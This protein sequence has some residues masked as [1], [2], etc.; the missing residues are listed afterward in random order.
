MVS[1]LHTLSKAF[2]NGAS[3]TNE[4]YNFKACLFDK[5]YLISDCLFGLDGVITAACFHTGYFML[6]SLRPLAD[7]AIKEDGAYAADA[8]TAYVDDFC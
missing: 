1:T 7:T 3:Y 8:F 4:V 2:A 5:F 6:K